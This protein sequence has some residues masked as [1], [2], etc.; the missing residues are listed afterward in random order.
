MISP[1]FI[2]VWIILAYT[3]AP[4]ILKNR[5]ILYPLAWVLLAAVVFFQKLPFLL[6]FIKGYIGF[7]LFY[8]VM[9]TGALNPKWKLTRK[10]QSVR[11]PYSILGF[12]FLLAHPLHYAPEVLSG[13][14]EIPLPGVIAFLVMVPLFVTS[15]MVIRKRMKAKTWKNLQKLAY[16]SYA[17]ILIHLIVNASTPVNRIVAIVLYIPYVGLKLLKEFKAAQML[18]KNTAAE[19]A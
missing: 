18:S 17:F 16:I 10:L 8:V 13:V 9:I 1:I 3:Q 2:A 19:N 5:K 6:P 4:F 11:A 14:R 15:Y 7:S 12:I